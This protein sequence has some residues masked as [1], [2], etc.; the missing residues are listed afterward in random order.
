MSIFNFQLTIDHYKGFTIL[1]TPGS[2]WLMN[3]PSFSIINYLL[4]IV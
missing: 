3:P 1:S 2:P 4:F